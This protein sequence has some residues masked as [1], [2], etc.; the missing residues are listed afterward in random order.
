[1]P[2]SIDGKSIVTLYYSTLHKVH[3][4]KQNF[5]LNHP[6]DLHDL[7]ITDNV[8]CAS[9]ALQVAPV[10][11]YCLKKIIGLRPKLGNTYYHITLSNYDTF[12]TYTFN[13]IDSIIDYFMHG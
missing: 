11:Y 9:L 10:S 2:V 8:D 6:K 1:V 13:L 4:S 5:Y 3:K 12:H 7:N